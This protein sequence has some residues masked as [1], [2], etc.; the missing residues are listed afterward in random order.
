MKYVLWVVA[1][2]VICSVVGV[3]WWSQVDTWRVPPPAGPP[4]DP[5]V[6]YRDSLAL[7]YAA[8]SGVQSGYKS[9]TEPDSAALAAA[10]EIGAQ[11]GYERPTTLDSLLRQV[12]VQ[13]DTIFYS[14][15]TLKL[16]A[17]AIAQIP[18]W[19]PKNYDQPDDFDGQ[20][21]AGYR[22]RQDTCWT[23]F[24]T[25]PLHPLGRPS[26][27]R[28][29]WEMR[30]YFLSDAFA[31]HEMYAHEDGEAVSKAFKYTPADTL[32]WTESLMWERG[33]LR[34]GYYYFET[35]RAP[36]MQDVTRTRVKQPIPVSYP[37]SIRQM[38]G[39]C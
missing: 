16:F 35:V 20:A 33:A 7:A 21:M 31:S 4:P 29:S 26:S 36:S 25:G 28:V 13:I 34:P 39:D 24:Y 10:E 6:Y 9:F 11:S 2:I 18:G 3:I 37:D 27:D 19:T 30:R 14:P 32:F 5:D 17:F 15:D 8:E 12:S 23:L 38:Y 22:T 1:A